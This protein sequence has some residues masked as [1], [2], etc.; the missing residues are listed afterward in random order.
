MACSELYAQIRWLS[1]GEQGKETLAWPT[2]KCH[3]QW[4]KEI[5]MD[6]IKKAWIFKH[7]YVLPSDDFTPTTISSLRQA[8][9][10]NVVLIF[11]ELDNHDG[12]FYYIGTLVQWDISV[13]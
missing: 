8:M 7:L 10:Q 4:G 3:E 1:Y 2:R 6:T 11:K 9:N 5:K 13:C 12:I